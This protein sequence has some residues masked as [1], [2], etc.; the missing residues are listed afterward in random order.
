[1]AMWNQSQA[2]QSE[3][4]IQPAPTDS[5]QCLAWSPVAD[6]LVAGSWDSSITIYLFYYILTPACIQIRLW[7]VNAQGQ[8]TPKFEQ[9]HKGPVLDVC[10][11]PSGSRV[12][13]ASADKELQMW[14]LGA[15]KLQQVGVHA[16]PIKCARW[17]PTLNCVMTGSWDKT[18]KF[19]DC[20]SPQPA[21]QFQM[22]ER[23]YAMDVCKNLA[24]VAT[25]EQKHIYSYNLDQAPKEYR[26]INTQLHMQTRCITCF[27]SADGFA[28]GSI[29]GR[30]GIQYIDAN[31][32]KSDDFSFK[33]HRDNQEN[34][35]HC[36]NGI[37][38]HPVYGTFATCGSDGRFVFWDKDARNKLKSF[39]QLP[40]LQPITSCSF[41]RNGTLFAYAHSYDWSKG[42]QYYN[43]ATAN[44]IMIHM[45][46]DSEIQKKN[47][48]GR[49]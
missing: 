17:C 6:F 38:F 5:V 24:V 20:R 39:P 8:N 29:E 22:P 16:E 23:V 30:V 11:E 49:R 44:S 26:K 31:R 10:W 36:V 18:I 25:A 47:P 27:P 48:M 19:W 28:V 37:S 14:D 33:C 2:Q 7:E 34:M 35:I 15:N 4:A 43:P 42:H 9:K 45:V 3:V 13:S 40:A 12:F 32:G 46:Q 1:M 21:A 41:N